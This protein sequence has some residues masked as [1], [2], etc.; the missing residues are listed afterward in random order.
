M[1]QDRNELEACGSLQCN[2]SPDPRLYS[3]FVI[4]AVMVGGYRA[5]GFM[6]R[7]VAGSVVVL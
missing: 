1:I 4:V 5:G 2:G 3:W 6:T 7:F